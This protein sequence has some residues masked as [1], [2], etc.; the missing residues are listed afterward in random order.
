VLFQGYVFTLTLGGNFMLVPWHAAAGGGYTGKDSGFIDTTA[1]GSEFG[2]PTEGVFDKTELPA[3]VKRTPQQRVESL[4]S[5]VGDDL[6]LY[7]SGQSD[8]IV[9]GEETRQ[10]AQA[11][12]QEADDSFERSESKQI[13]R[14]TGSQYA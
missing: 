5:K 12:L 4:M 1:G 9:S 3:I 7:A 6:R 8:R 11:A 2:R 13:V 10:I 14:T